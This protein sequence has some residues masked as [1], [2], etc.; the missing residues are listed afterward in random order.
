MD[1]KWTSA[2][3]DAVMSL[4]RRAAE[5]KE[6]AQRQRERTAEILDV[7]ANGVAR[8]IGRPELIRRA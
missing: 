4:L 8:D 1:C 2:D 3:R 7:V 6:L 5:F